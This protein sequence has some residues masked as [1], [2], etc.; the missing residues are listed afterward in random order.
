MN[1]NFEEIDRQ[2]RLKVT[3]IFFVITLIL[4]LFNMTMA[5]MIAD[6]NY[7]DSSGVFNFLYIIGNALLMPFFITNAVQI[8]P[9][10]RN[11]GSRVRWFFSAT[12]I[13]FLLLLNRSIGLGY[14]T[15]L[16]LF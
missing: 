2:R 6:R 13:M 16:Q 9:K 4:I 5:Y 11:S 8:I 3:K 10:Y 1:Q 14:I 7:P 15:E 12:V